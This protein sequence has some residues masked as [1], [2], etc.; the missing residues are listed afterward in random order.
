MAKAMEMPRSKTFL[1]KEGPAT[2]SNKTIAH[3]RRLISAIF[4]A[5]MMVMIG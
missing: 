1:V 3:H 2:L 5:T 4:N